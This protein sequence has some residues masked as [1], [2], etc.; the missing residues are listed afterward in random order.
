MP[1]VM[2]H[3]PWMELVVESAI[4]N[5]SWKHTRLSIITLQCIDDVFVHKSYRVVHWTGPPHFQCWKMPCS[6]LALLIHGTLWT[7]SLVPQPTCWWKFSKSDGDPV[8]RWK[9]FSFWYWKWGGGLVDSPICSNYSL[10]LKLLVVKNQYFCLSSSLKK[11]QPV[12][13]LMG[14]NRCY[15]A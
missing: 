8:S 4:T 10:K 15:R 2:G 3:N 14:R 13:F 9:S 5:S 11:D 1:L 6:Q 7:Y 12:L